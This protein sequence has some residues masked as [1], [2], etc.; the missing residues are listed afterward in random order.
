MGDLSGGYPLSVSTGIDCMP[1]VLGGGG[2]G[3]DMQRE[4]S[5]C[6]RSC[7]CLGLAHTQFTEESMGGG[8]MGGGLRVPGGDLI[9]TLSASAPGPGLE[10]LTPPTAP[11]AFPVLL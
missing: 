9:P 11:L 5:P 4:L 10:L 1:V 7:V 3:S 6:C 8:S 2:M